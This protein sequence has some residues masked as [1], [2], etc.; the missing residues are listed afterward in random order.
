MGIQTLGQDNPWNKKWQPTPV[1]LLGELHGQRRLVGY[2]PR[3]QKESNTTEQLN[4]NNALCNRLQI[5]VDVWQK[6][7]QY[8]KVIFLELNKLIKTTGTNV[9]M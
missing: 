3:G 7:P 1:F 4:N 5:H 2:S 9:F 8:C 6:S